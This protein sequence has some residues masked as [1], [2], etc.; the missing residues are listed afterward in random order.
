MTKTVTK[1]K[2]PAV[3]LSK[4]L[5]G[6]HGLDE[7]TG[8][9]LPQGR[10]TLVCGGAGCGKT[11]LGIEFLVRGAMLHDEPGVF[12]AFEE[13]AE[14]LAQNVRSLGFDLDDLIEK[15]K[16]AVDY[17]HIE[18]NDIE[19]TGDYDLEGL[20]I[21]LNHAI[22]SIGAKRVVLDTLETLFSGLSNVAVLRSELRRL[23]RWLKDKGVTA[24][25]TAERGN[26]SFTRHGMEEYV[27][28]CVL[29]LD[30]RVDGQISTRRLRIVKYRGSS[31]ATNEFPF[32]IDEGGIS[33]FPITSLQ[34]MHKASSERIS[35][36]V[37]A[38]DAMLGGQGYYTRKQCP[39]VRH[40]W[41]KA[42]TSLAKRAMPRM[43]AADRVKLLSVHRVS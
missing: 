14:E 37:A 6:I 20:F 7:I 10:P 40:G 28:D 34:L 18:P 5:T 9:G 38:L 42:S 4:C 8:G 3:S 27:S 35:S 41:C 24:V 17:I 39:V 29:L 23:F 26:G 33:V 11:L 19:E 15:K 16:L 21:R 43:P 12:L 13:T 32:L 31:H 1:P 30:H 2:T 36:G 25:I 22:D